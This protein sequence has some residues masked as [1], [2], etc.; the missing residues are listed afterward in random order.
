MNEKACIYCGSTKL[1]YTTR[2]RT[3]C[4][5]CKK[6]FYPGTINKLYPDFHLTR[7]NPP[8]TDSINKE[9]YATE[10]ID[11]SGNKKYEM[12]SDRVKTLDDFVK[13]RNIDL[14]K[15][16]V[17]FF[18]CTNWEMAYGNQNR[19]DHTVVPLYRIRARF[20]PIVST[21]LDQAIES[22]INRLN[23][24]APYVKYIPHI[25]PKKYLLEISLYDHHF[26]KL[27]W[28]PETNNTYDLKI[29]KELYV[30]AVSDLLRKTSAYQLDEILLVIGQDFLNINNEA[31]TTER[32]TEQDCDSR[33]GKIID[34]ATNSLHDAIKEMLEYS[35]VKI[36]WVPGNHDRLTSYTICKILEAYYKNDERIVFDVGWNTRKYVEFGKVLIGYTH[37]HDEKKGSLPLIMAGEVPELWGRTKYREIHT[38]HF[39]TRKQTNYNSNDTIHGIPVKVLGSLTATDAWHY[40]KGFVNN[41]RH[42]ECF[43]WDSENGLE[44]EFFHN[45]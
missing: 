2:N 28:E 36:L 43:L 40:R 33:L 45:L 8:T 37:G 15:Y 6:T 7:Q 13:D 38:G 29:A 41:I 21:S 26:G 44:G 25:K 9:I 19:T 42:A 23:T 3:Y 30:N 17:S 31:G 24:P 35:R 20:V 14:T 12:V 27:A 34:V 11:E 1:T 39:H 10:S 4:L 16:K 32:G 5:Q 22:F 18:E